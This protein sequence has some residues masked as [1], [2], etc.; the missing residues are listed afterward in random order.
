MPPI[1]RKSWDHDAMIRAV[2]AVRSKQMGYLK[3]SKHFG[4]PKGTLERYVKKDANAEVLVKVHMGRPPALPAYLE[5]ELEK[6][7]KELD[8]RFYGLRLKDIK[9]MAFQLAIMNNLKYPFSLTKASAGKQWLRGFMSRHHDLSV[10]TPEAVS[11][12]RVK[13]FNPVAVNHFFDFYEP[14]IDKIKSPSH[15]VYNFDETGITV[16]QHKRSKVISVKGKK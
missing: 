5:A 15:R 1:K 4:V 3:A 9:H 7:C 2:N 12:A 6:Y 16:V 14:E 8:Q 13:G 10:R 11:A